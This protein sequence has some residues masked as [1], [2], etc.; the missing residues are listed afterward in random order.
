MVMTT[1]TYEFMVDPAQLPMITEA[2]AEGGY[3]GMQTFDQHLMA[4]YRQGEVSLRDALGTATSPH[5]FRV[6]LR[7]AGLAS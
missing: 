3:Y 1:R 7:G 5:D 6:A 4:L 2:I